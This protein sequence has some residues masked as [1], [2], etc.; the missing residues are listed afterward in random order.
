MHK[1]RSISLALAMLVL[2]G[3][4]SVEVRKVPTPSQYEN[5]SDKLQK[6]ADDME[7]L[8]FYLPRP[9]INVF[10]S[11]PVSTDVYF[12]NGKVS[13]DGR[14]VIIS[15]VRADSPFI[16]LF[17]SRLQDDGSYQVEIDEAF[18]Q[19][20]EQPQTDA[21][22]LQSAIE[23]AAKKAATSKVEE[24][25]SDAKKAAKESKS[26]AESARRDANRADAASQAEAPR[27]GVSKRAAKND[28]GAFAVQPLRGNFDVVY[29]PDFEEQFVVSSKSG[30]G[31]AQFEINLGQGW[32]LQG[33]NSLVDNSEINKRVFDLIDTSIAAAKT[34]AGAAAPGLPG[35][36]AGGAVLQS[37][38]D[39]GTEGQQLPKLRGVN[40]T[41]RV[42]I[43]H[44]AAK[45]L[46]PVLKPRELLRQVPST[47]VIDPF[48]SGPVVREADTITDPQIR[49]AIERHQLD[50]GRYTVPVYPYQYI[51][52]NTFRYVAVEALTAS[53]APFGTLY[54]PTGVS[55]DRGDARRTDPA[56]YS[57][58]QKPDGSAESKP[59]SQIAQELQSSIVDNLKENAPE[60]SKRL[61][62]GAKL[63]VSLRSEDPPAIEVRLTGVRNKF[64][65]AERKA[66]K[67][68]ATAQARNYRER[69]ETHLIIPLSDEALAKFKKQFEETNPGLGV[70]IFRTDDAKHEYELSHADG[71]TVT[72]E[73]VAKLQ[74]AWK[75]LWK[76]NGG[77]T[78][79]AAGHLIEKK[80]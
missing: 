33:F 78:D 34:A 76:Q 72:P 10:E 48:E 43:V 9:F 74:D 20:P 44:Y 77:H 51:S 19:I 38:D 15:D 2:A 40:V 18:V 8:R 75:G 60:F 41:I 16:G 53:G 1:N 31:N 70:N 25:A 64:S 11:F 37:A 30:L 67:D 4:A 59:L 57:S 36:P 52:F 3:C 46:Y 58:P 5:W 50:K 39:K 56:T 24:S 69:F 79:D 62:S 22:T 63:T 80:R 17:A 28:N 7:G 54:D 12:V 61:E 23:E 71:S 14:Y 27:T 49:D 26:S 45:G 21:A 32:S 65:D 66:V 29:L 55:G 6:E 35:V 47:V 73:E 13:P 42:V 68:V